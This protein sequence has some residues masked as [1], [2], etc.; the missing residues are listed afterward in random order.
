MT[1]AFNGAQ[2][3]NRSVC[4]E[5]LSVAE[6][7]AAALSSRRRTIPSSVRIINERLIARFNH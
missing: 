3:L 5:G 4:D 6:L 7:G 1:A 2:A